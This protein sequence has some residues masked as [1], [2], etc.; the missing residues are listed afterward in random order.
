MLRF[1]HDL[2]CRNPSKSS[3]FG[4]APNI[5]PSDH[6]QR[7]EC[8][9]FPVPALAGTGSLR[10]VMKSTRRRMIRLMIATTTS[11]WSA[12]AAAYCVGD[13]ASLP[14]F[15]AKYYSIS[16][17]Y[18]RAKYV[19]RARVVR[20]TWLG[21]DGKPKALKPPFQN[22]NPRPWGFDPYVG[23]Y[24][25]VKVTRSFK[26][27]APGELRL[28]SENSTTRFWLDVGSDVVLFVTEEPFD[29]PIGT[30]LTVDTCGNSALSD[31][32][33][34][35]LSRLARLAGGHSRK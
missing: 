31:K 3:E 19:A 4:A 32:S 5:W 25:D 24:Y 9:L 21:E 8:L 29:E 11:A 13:D 23:V 30:Q 7:W 2:V 20:E 27:A 26:G 6:L 34:P 16:H 35:M 22:G 12:G 18:R 15:D 1:D 33:G 28:F 17:E 10:L 14:N